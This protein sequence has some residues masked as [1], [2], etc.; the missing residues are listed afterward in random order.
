MYIFS[1]L[2]F[3]FEKCVEE[4]FEINTE[5]FSFKFKPI[6]DSRK[7]AKTKVSP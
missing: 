7:T 2:K 1:I 4:T 5:P 6:R 3:H